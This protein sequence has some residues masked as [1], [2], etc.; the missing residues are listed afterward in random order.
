M[1]EAIIITKILTQVRFPQNE[2]KYE[3]NYVLL[4]PLLPGMN[5]NMYWLNNHKHYL[6]NIAN[7]KK[8]PSSIE[9]QGAETYPWIPHIATR[10]N[11]Y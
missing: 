9:H 2:E 7:L 10:P 4:L 5:E 8:V 11:V 1:H 3:G 6:E